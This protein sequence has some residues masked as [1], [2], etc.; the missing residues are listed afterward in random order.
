MLIWMS[1]GVSYKYAVSC[2]VYTYISNSIR[3]DILLLTD[4]PEIISVDNKVY[5]SFEKGEKMKPWELG[6]KVVR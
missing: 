4:V 3:K 2:H 6:G 5:W 1:R